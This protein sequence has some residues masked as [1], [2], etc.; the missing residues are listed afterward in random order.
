MIIHAD[1]TCKQISGFKWCNKL[2]KRTEKTSYFCKSNSSFLYSWILGLHRW[3]YSPSWKRHWSG[4]SSRVLLIRHAFTCWNVQCTKAA[5]LS[6]PL[7]QDVPTSSAGAYSSPVEPRRCSTMSLG[8]TGWRWCALK[9]SSFL[10]A[11]APG[12]QEGFRAGVSSW[13]WLEIPAY[14]KQE[15]KFWARPMV[16]YLC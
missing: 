9:R 7:I 16:F 5:T 3:W 6:F 4:C 10:S 15:P 2:K 12:Y 1:D 8:A 13:I 11:N 14:N